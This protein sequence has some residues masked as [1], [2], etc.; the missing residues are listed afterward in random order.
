MDLFWANRSKNPLFAKYGTELESLNVNR[1]KGIR[2]C[3][4]ASRSI[5]TR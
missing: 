5:I 3:M 2:A 1:V 4:Y